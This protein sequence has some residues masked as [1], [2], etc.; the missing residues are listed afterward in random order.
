MIKIYERSLLEINDEL[1]YVASQPTI[2]WYLSA[3]IDTLSCDWIRFQRKNPNLPRCVRNAIEDQ[4][5][6]AWRRKEAWAWKNFCSD[7]PVA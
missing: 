5:V 1:V 3:L 2:G 4:F 6:D 7:R